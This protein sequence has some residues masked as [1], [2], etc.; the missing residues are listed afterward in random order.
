M[1]QTALLSS[2][3]SHERVILPQ[4]SHQMRKKDENTER[5]P[6]RKVKGKVSEW[7]FLHVFLRFFQPFFET[8]LSLSGLEI[9]WEIL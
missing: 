5:T 8:V 4:K 3:F 2:F 1:L 7:G 9:A 6:V